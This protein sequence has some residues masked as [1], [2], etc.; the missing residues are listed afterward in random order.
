MKRI[1]TVVLVGTFVSILAASEPPDP[2]LRV[3]T[4]TDGSRQL[5]VV[6][7]TADGT[8]ESL[9]AI[10]NA[11]DVRVTGSGVVSAEAQWIAWTE[12]GSPYYSLSND[13]GRKWSRP[14]RYSRALRL[15]GRDVLPDEDMPDPAIPM[16]ASGRLFIVQARV[17]WQPSMVLE[18]A[19]L[20][21][22]LLSYVHN[23]AFL[24]RCE[25]PAMAAS[26]VRRSFVERVEPYACSMR[27][28]PDL[29]GWLESPDPDARETL[30]VNFI[31]VK[32]DIRR[33]IASFARGLG[34]DTS[35]E[36]AGGSLI[37]LTVTREQLRRLACHDD[38]QYAD[39]WMPPETQMDDVRADAGAD[40]LEEPMNGGYCGTGVR[41]EV[42]DDGFDLD[43][44]EYA[45]RMVVHGTVDP[46]TT[47]GTSTFGIVFSAGTVDPRSKGT[48]PCGTG[49]AGDFDEVTCEGC[50]RFDY[51]LDS[52]DVYNA[53]FQTN[54]WSQGGYSTDY[55]SASYNL[56]EIIWRL[57]MAILQ[58]IGN[59][60]RYNP[61]ACTQETFSKNVI[62]VGATH[63]H[64]TADPSD[65]WWCAHDCATLHAG[66][67]Q[68]C[69]DD[70]YCYWVVGSCWDAWTDCANIGP[71]ADGRIKPDLA[72]WY[73]NIYTTT[74]D[75]DTGDDGYQDDFWGTSGSTPQV[76][77]V[78]GLILEMWADTSDGGVNPWGHSPAGS[79]PFEKQPHAATLKALLINSAHQYPFSG[80]AHDLTRMHQGW[81]RP[82]A[83]SALE[84][85]AR[86]LV[87]DEEIS[88]QA[89]EK[90]IWTVDVAPGEEEL[91]ATLSYLDPPKTLSTGGK[92]LINDLDLRVVSP[93]DVEGNVTVYCGNAGLDAETVSAVLWTG[94][95]PASATPDC[96]D[97]AISSHRDSLNNVENVFVHENS[98]GEGIASGTWTVEIKAYEVNTDGNPNLS[99][100]E[101]DLDPDDPEAGRAACEAA[102]CQWDGTRGIC[103]D[104]TFDVVFGLVVTGAEVPMPGESNGLVMSKE[105]DGSLTL[106]W[107]PDCGGG[108]TYGIYRGDLN[109]GYDSV[110]P[111]PGM[112]AVSGSAATLPAGTGSAD[113]FLVVPNDGATEGSYGT[114][115]EDV[116]RTPADSPC[117]V[118]GG[119]H[120][121]AR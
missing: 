11:L 119:I 121:C 86:S 99:C 68:G 59:D 66:N 76:A 115:S 93:P 7:D 49:I 47:H 38:V 24:A 41:G 120:N 81:G 43:H 78:L 92:E 51:T 15:K 20:G 60:G 94:P 84:R 61:Q 91:R 18:S 29:L 80:A 35:A 106:T 6:A 82:N 107:D 90:Q 109:A 105:E 100:R 112:C 50:S 87:V 23:Q 98:P 104:F 25:S 36:S 31:T 64:D 8:E 1:A 54:S 88:L 65:D 113:F 13:G 5:T 27:L 118:Q 44:Q 40:W 2:K 58:A 46:N 3:T 22:E 97:P 70:V 62:A 30:R 10:T 96:D 28:A 37:D 117:H 55:G 34:V 72:Y 83:R 57:D 14:H 103:G 33:E 77:G 63:H 48:L 9:L 75:P 16:P 67:Q 79:S 4:S 56:E 74:T 52:R 101:I 32:P 39:R 45:D 21:C 114:D 85:A 116:R 19:D 17:P 12:D 110:A 53:S 102:G 71:T 69:A 73:D 42:L 89:G 26:L 111:E 95:G 108:T